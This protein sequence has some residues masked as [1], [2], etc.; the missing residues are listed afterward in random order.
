[1]SGVIELPRLA[2]TAEPTARSPTSSGSAPAG[3]PNGWCGRSDV[4]DLAA[5]LAELDPAVPVLPRR[6][7]LEPDRPRRR[8]ARRGRA[9]AQGDA[10][11]PCRA[12]QPRARAAAGRWASP[13]PRKARD[14]Q[15]RRPRIPSRH[16]RHGRR[17]GADERRRL[18][19][20]GRRHPGRG[21]ARAAR[22][23]GRDLAAPSGSATPTATARCPRA[24]SWSRRLFEG[25]PGDRAA[26]GAEMDRIAAEREASQPLR[27]RTG[28]S[29]F[30]NP[31]GTKAWQLIDAAGCRGPARS[32]MPKS[33]KSIATSCSTS[34]APERRHRGARR[35]G[36]ARSGVRDRP[37]WEI[38]RVGECE[39]A[40]ISGRA[41]RSAVCR[42]REGSTSSTRR[43]SGVRMDKL[44][45]A[46]LMGGWSA[47]REVSLISG[48]RRRRG[49]GEPRP[50]RHPD[51]HGPQR[52]RNASPRPRPT[53]CSTRF[54]ARPA[55]TARSRA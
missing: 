33:L 5:F 31:P 9:A 1:M 45:V 6:G 18:W 21:D 24:R 30:K 43:M 53:S 55:R 48:S 29:T 3:R 16:S 42:S 11:R 26:I 14:A 4:E 38:Q 17:R 7:R 34:A 46:V 23:R 44:H 19:P 12:R 28:G 22:R 27:S 41:C 47:E 52:R 49:A 2:G 25:V 35:G 15:H 54:T 40:Q 32:A 20:R 8:R 10:P 37:R 36:P 50:S 51:R 13:S 39:L